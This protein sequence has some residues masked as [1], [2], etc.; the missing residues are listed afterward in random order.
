M[1]V[2]CNCEDCFEVVQPLEELDYECN[3]SQKD[4]EFECDCGRIWCSNEC[5]SKDGLVGKPVYDE[6]VSERNFKI[7]EEYD[8]IFTL[9]RKQVKCN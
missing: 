3:Y 2:L 8:A 4:F 9:I 5:A 6:D 1:S 7:Q